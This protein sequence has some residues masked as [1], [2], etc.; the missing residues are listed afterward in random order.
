[1]ITKE[2]ARLFGFVFTVVAILYFFTYLFASARVFRI[3]SFAFAIMLIIAFA[4]AIYMVYRIDVISQKISP[5]AEETG[6]QQSAICWIIAILLLVAFLFHDHPWVTTRFENLYSVYT[7][8]C[9]IC[10]NKAYEVKLWDI[11]LT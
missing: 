11:A 9:L 8:P 4:I 3:A 1:M 10:H 6:H 5:D 2:N 7:S